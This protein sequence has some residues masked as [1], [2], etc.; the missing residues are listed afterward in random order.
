[1]PTL[2]WDL[3]NVQNPD[4]KINFKGFAVGN[5]Y[6]DPVSNGIFGTYPTFWGRSLISTPTWT[7]FTQH[8][9]TK[10]DSQCDHWQNVASA[11]IGD[12]DPYGLTWPV[13]RLD[14]AEPKRLLQ[15]TV[16]ASR[17]PWSA[18]NGKTAA[19]GEPYPYD[20][21]TEDYAVN[22]LNRADV[23]KA[24]HANAA[25]LPWNSCS[26]IVRYNMSDLDTPMEPL[27]NQLFAAAPNLK[28]LV[29]SGDDDSVCATLGSQYWIYR[30]NMQTKQAWTSWMYNKQVG[31]YIVKFKSM[32]FVT[33]RGAG[34]MVPQY[35]PA[36]GLEVFRKYLDGSWF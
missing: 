30:M 2:A 29:Y 4:P 32:S 8:C 14:T 21:C 24:I 17:R 23:V 20:P 15:M 36:L 28:I 11:E 13:C 3:V 5:P 35:K 1:M 31:G 19:V 33:V 7:S 6:T 12:L 9:V 10:P 27:Y 18:V 25:R 22:Y 16:P 34:H 26:D